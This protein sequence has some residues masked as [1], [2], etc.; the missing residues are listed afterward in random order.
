[1]GDD[2]APQ[3]FEQYRNTAGV[4]EVF[5]EMDPTWPWTDGLRHLVDCIESGA[6]TVTRP[7]HAYHALEVML[8]ATQSAQEGR[9][10]DIES[11]FPELDYSSL[12][13]L[14]EDDRRIH[15]PRTL[16]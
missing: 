5:P 2:W 13:P 14:A 1:M 15:D 9:F 4:W 10:V 8:A 11:T 12:V 7:E 6:P 16:V 3:G